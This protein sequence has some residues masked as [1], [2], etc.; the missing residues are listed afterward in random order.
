MLS[1]AELNKA[2]DRAV[3]EAYAHYLSNLASG[4]DKISEIQFVGTLLQMMQPWTF[5][6]EEAMEE[7]MN[8]IYKDAL[9]ISFMYNMTA[10]FRQRFAVSKEDYEL[11]IK[12]VAD[13]FFTQACE[14]DNLSMMA[15]EYRVRLSSGESIEVMLKNNRILVM[16][17]TMMLYFDTRILAAALGGKHE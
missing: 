7:M 16:L 6:T 3:N 9:Y 1:I 11:Y 10:L 15:T 8:A 14:N 17:V 4:Q 13:S 2:A 5:F 12:H